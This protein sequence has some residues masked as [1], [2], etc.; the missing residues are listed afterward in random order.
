MNFS[1][2]LK[3]QLSFCSQDLWIQSSGTWRHF[4]ITQFSIPVWQQCS[5]CVGHHS[6]QY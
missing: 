4:H 1:R 6:Y 2:E 3:C 5:M